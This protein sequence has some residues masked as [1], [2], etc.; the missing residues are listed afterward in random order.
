MRSSIVYLLMLLFF[1]LLSSPPGSV[2]FWRGFPS[3]V[4]HFPR[5]QSHGGFLLSLT[6][7][8]CVFFVIPHFSRRAALGQRR[9]CSFSPLR[10]RRGTPLSAAAR[11]PRR[12]CVFPFCSFFGVW[13]QGGGFFPPLCPRARG[14]LSLVVS[15]PSG[16]TTGRSFFPKTGDFRLL[17]FFF[18]WRI[19][20]FKSPPTYS[21]ARTAALSFFPPPFLQGRGRDPPDTV[22]FFLFS[23]LFWAEGVPRF[24]ALCFSNPSCQGAG[25]LFFLQVPLPSPPNS[26]PSGI[27][28]GRF[29][30]MSPLSFLVFFLMKEE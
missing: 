17:G 4:R 2:F 22:V 23:S 14:F 21:S 25:P 10:R 1:F 18:P 15:P 16:P 11:C 28:S 24:F 8:R 6:G 13:G 3:R 5:R 26:R 20:H 27:D 19:Q 30:P 9:F 12:Y 7:R 29:V